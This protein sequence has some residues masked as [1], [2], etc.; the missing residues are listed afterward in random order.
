MI[1]S[2]TLDPTNTVGSNLYYL[3]SNQLNVKK[4]LTSIVFDFFFVYVHTNN[5]ILFLQTLELKMNEK[6]LLQLEDLIWKDDEAQ[7]IFYQH[8]LKHL[9]T[10]ILQDTTYE[11]G[12][13]DLEYHREVGTLL[14]FND[15]CRYDNIY[16]E[17]F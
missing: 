2:N 8:P 10:K 7:V 13:V 12:L 16:I 6:Q 11:S 5:D 9:V 14:K 15:I 17:I 3:I 1:L 4:K